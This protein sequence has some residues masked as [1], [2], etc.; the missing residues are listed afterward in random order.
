MDR[1]ILGHR[2]ILGSNHSRIGW[3]NMMSTNRMGLNQVS[4]V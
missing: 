1:I 3:M 4:K 2:T